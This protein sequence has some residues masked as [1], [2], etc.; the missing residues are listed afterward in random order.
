MRSNCGTNFI[1]AE[2]ELTTAVQEINHNRLKEVLSNKYHADWIIDWKR[3]SQDLKFA[4]SQ[5]P[6]ENKAQNKL[7]CSVALCPDYIG[8]LQK[9]QLFRS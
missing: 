6:Q 4:E 7:C 5:Y 3:N 1:G 8:P 9:T 2:R